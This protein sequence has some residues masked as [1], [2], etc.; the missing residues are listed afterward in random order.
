ME[1]VSSVYDS[2]IDYDRVRLSLRTVATNG[3]IAHPPGDMWAW[4]AMVIIM[5]AGDNS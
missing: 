2:L 3:P 1:M 4:S 5:P